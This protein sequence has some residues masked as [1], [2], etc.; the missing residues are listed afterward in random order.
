[1]KKVE[2]GL[3]SVEIFKL[4]GYDPNILGKQRI[5]MYIKNLKKSKLT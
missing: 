5:Y 3:T 1:M 4:A 2:A